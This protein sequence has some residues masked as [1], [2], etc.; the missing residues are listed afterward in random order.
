VPGTE[1]QSLNILL[2]NSRQDP[3]GLLIRD[4]LKELLP[5]LGPEPVTI[6]GHRI[7]HREFG[8]RLIYADRFDSGTDADLI[9]FLSRHSSENPV[10]VLTTH[11]RGNF[12]DAMLGG[13]K[14]ALAPAAP[15]VMQAVLRALK[16]NAP[17]GYRVA[18]EV[19]HHGPTELGIP[20]CFV[21]IGSM[22]TEWRDP[23]AGKAV[24]QSVL[25]AIGSI[26]QDAVPMIG[27]GGTHY[28]T[29][30]TEIALATR[31]AF[32][33]IAH[34]REVPM[35]GEAMIRLMAERTG[36]VA[37]YIDKKALPAPEVSRIGAILQDAGLLLMSESEIGNLGTLSWDGYRRIIRKAAEADPGA[38]VHIGRME[39]CGE[40]YFI[41]FS[42]DLLEEVVKT[43]SAALVS[44]LSELP[45]V[46]LSTPK[47]RVLPLFIACGG[48]TGQF[49]NALI[50][51][52]V[53]LIREKKT[54]AIE[55]DH[56]IIREVRFDPEKAQNLGLSRGPLFSRLA[57]GQPVEHEG[58]VITPEM[59]QSC[60][61]RRI[62]IPGLER[63]Q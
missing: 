56:L 39:D 44:G 33:H 27:F 26:P 19:T 3:A 11:V 57:G 18:Y 23:A 51:L 38:R 5:C 17:A 6:A 55:R 35:L 13:K 47:R 45:L 62:H 16:R 50:T 2:V 31:G 53:K 20:S 24:A 22:E 46:H 41:E 9:L 37:A 43:D 61:E 40:P 36:A 32:G 10:P 1:N 60:S 28:A 48:S 29:R 30:E 4:Q 21:E 59:V 54:A 7:S 14:G 25:E 15:P 42:P 34:T 12:R 52:C 49:I 63:Y 8:E 58:R